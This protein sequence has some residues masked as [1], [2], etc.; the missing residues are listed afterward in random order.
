MP[1]IAGNIVRG[2]Y[3]RVR[4]RYVHRLIPESKTPL[5]VHQ[6]EAVEVVG[7]FSLAAGVGESARLCVESLTAAQ[8]SVRVRDLGQTFLKTIEVRGWR[9]ECSSA[10]QIGCRIYHLNPPMM[11]PAIVAMGLRAHLSAYNIGYWAWELDRLPSEWQRALRYVNAIFVPSNF[12]RDAIQKYTDKPVLVVP[13]PVRVRPY[14]ANVRDRLGIPAEAFLV[15]NVFSFGSSFGRKNPV[16]VVRAFKK[17]FGDSPNAYLVLKGSHGDETPEHKAEL[18]AA[19]I[20]SA[21]ILL[22]DAVWPAAQVAGLIAASDAYVSLH[23]SEGFGLTVAEAMLLNVPVIATNWSGNTDFCTAE[24]SFL[25]EARSIPV[26]DTHA[27]Y[28]HMQAVQWAD[29]NVEHAAAHLRFIFYNRFVAKNKAV[30]A[31]QRVKA[32][33]TKNTYASALEQL[34]HAGG[35]VVSDV[36]DRR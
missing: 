9:P 12:T 35:G 31:S 32:H 34:R 17:A 7:F 26:C 4:A 10:G 36:G 14:E 21:R 33:V 20:D 29:P 30:A 18:S 8:R 22:F 11:P 16:A 28:R 19:I 23:R 5:F 3:R 13:H 24:T 27:E 25:V 1:N 2:A 6:R 15:S